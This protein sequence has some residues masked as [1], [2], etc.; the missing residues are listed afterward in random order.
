MFSNNKIYAIILGIS[1]FFTDAIA[2]F[3]LTTISLEF[4]IQKSNLDF[5][6]SLFFYFMLYNFIAFW[7][8]F[9][10]WYF[11]DKTKDNLKSFLVSKYLIFI[12]FIFYLIGLSFILLEGF[13][14]NFILFGVI[15]V[16]LGS[17][18]FH[19][20]AWNIS[21]LSNCK[22]ATILWIFASGWVV[23]L[24]FWFFVAV[25]YSSLYFIF[26]IFLVILALIIY[27]FES[28]N[29]DK[30]NLINKVIKSE[31]ILKNK[32]LLDKYWYFFILS[33]LSILAFRSAIWTN[34]QYVFYDD[35]MI[36]FYLAISAFLWKIIWWVLEDQKFFKDKYFIL[37]WIMSIIL[38]FIYIFIFQNIFLILFW[39]FWITL[40]ISPITII[41]FELFRE[42]K[43]I[44]IS[45]TFWLSLI[46]WYWIFKIFN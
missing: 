1:H 34:Y 39:I 33:L 19:I 28:Y 43:A 14:I 38:F 27:N 35:K 2:S 45:Y 21:L 5:W 15:F 44:I 7:W 4:L 36:I 8:Q 40:F 3:I 30:D 32:Y 12:S 18:F 11:L 29:L 31:K 24:S 16:W 25:F 9:L 37:I 10:I 13:V 17:S 20:W 26:Y 41:I 46:F 23:W 6:Y 22:K 42:N